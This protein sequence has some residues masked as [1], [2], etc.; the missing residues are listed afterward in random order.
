M[1]YALTTLLP[2]DIVWFTI[3]DW[4]S[5]NKSIFPVNNENTTNIRNRMMKN[6]LQS[7][8]TNQWVRRLCAHYCKIEQN[9]TPHHIFENT[10]KKSH[11]VTHAIVVT[12]DF[13]SVQLNCWTHFMLLV[14]KNIRKRLVFWCF[15]GYTRRPQTWNDLETLCFIKIFKYR[16]ENPTV[17]F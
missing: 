14:S 13:S 4:I 17:F 2:C 12:L 10:P 1:L 15:Q 11:L 3:R 16:T 7:L 9:E 8:E 5:R 6:L